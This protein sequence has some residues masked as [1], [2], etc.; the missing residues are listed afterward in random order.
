MNR[1]DLYEKHN[2]SEFVWG[3]SFEIKLNDFDINDNEKIFK[4]FDIICERENVTKLSE[5]W[6]ELSQMEAKELLENAFNR[7]LAY[8]S[9]INMPIEKAKKI[10]KTYFEELESNFKS[11]TNWD[12]NPWTSQNGAGWNPITHNTFDMAILLIDKSKLIFTYFISED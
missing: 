9:G 3:D 11:F 5:S 12:R 8:T 10:T 7:D 6:Y 4:F 2:L 1:I